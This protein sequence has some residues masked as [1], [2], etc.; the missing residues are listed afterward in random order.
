MA[1]IIPFVCWRPAA[2][3][4]SQV[5]AAPYDTLSRQEATLE[6]AV[7]PLSF[8]R[9]DKPAAL[10]SAEVDE[11]DEQVYE[12]AGLELD[13]WYQQGVLIPDTVPAEPAYFIYRLTQA[14]HQQTGLIAAASVADYKNGVIKRHENTQAKK[15]AD[16]VKHIKALAA[17]TGPV[18]LT[19]P[20][21]RQID[22]LLKE[23]TSQD[24]L[25]PDAQGQSS[26]RP[27]A[28]LLYDFHA[29]DGVRHEFWR[30]DSKDI[31][32]RIQALFAEVPTLYIA[33]GHHRAAAAAEVASWY[34]ENQ[35]EGLA[36]A[37]HF[38]VAVFGSQE[39]Q[40]LDYNRLVADLAGQSPEEILTALDD[41]VTVEASGAVPYRPAHKGEIAMYLA[42]VWYRLSLNESQRPQDAV[43]SLDVALLHKLIL[44]PILKIVD[45]R[46]DPRI[47]YVGG[48][49]GLTFLAEQVD[50]TGGVAFALYPCSLEELFAVANEDRLMP[51]KSTWF[52]P[53]PKSGLAIH[54]FRTI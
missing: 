20:S 5:A 26:A 47:S 4:A 15:E 37:Q 2:E 18:L 6:T 13:S 35:M 1:E 24:P 21:V 31:T 49:R 40:V 36:G 7:H 51:P 30:L 41:V 33:D 8:L 23:I 19:Y 34:A 12:A 10:F 25:P 9:I 52:E 54:R 32:Q 22:D 29:A 42:G 27:P 45:P 28:T 16:R 43:E 50:K 53:K 11:Y 17:H 14:E 46:S 38:L 48:A 39:L 44:A 3:L